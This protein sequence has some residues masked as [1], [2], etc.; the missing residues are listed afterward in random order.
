MLIGTADELPKAPEK[1]IIFME[2][3][4]EDQLQELAVGFIRDIF[5]L[6]FHLI[7]PTQSLSWIK[8]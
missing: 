4:P 7:Q 1:A 5:Y 2:D 6:Y 3:L 8:K